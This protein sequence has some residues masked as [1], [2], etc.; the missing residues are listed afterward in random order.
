MAGIKI[1][2]YAPMNVQGVK[3]GSNQ[4]DKQGKVKHQRVSY[5]DALKML[6]KSIAEFKHPT[7]VATTYVEDYAGGSS[8]YLNEEMVKEF[9]K[10]LTR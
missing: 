7:D 8:A 4:M 1:I 2:R 9:I 6:D 5:S 3:S 10:K